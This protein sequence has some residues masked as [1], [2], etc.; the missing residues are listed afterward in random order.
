MEYIIIGSFSFVLFVLYDWNQI[1]SKSTLFK[2][3]FMLG[4]LL[5]IFTTGLLW[6]NDGSGRFY[7][8]P[9]LSLLFGLLSIISGAVLVYILFFAIPFEKAYVDGSRQE[10]VTEGVY[11]I[12]RHPGVWFL[13]FLYLFA[14]IA[15]GRPQIILGSFVFS[16]FN[17]LYVF[18]Q[19]RIFF[20]RIFAGYSEYKEK[21]SFIVPTKTGICNCFRYYSK[22]N[23]K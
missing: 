1:S 10:L 7:V 11:A 13:F 14:G 12:C 19:D 8:S 21:T 22:L 15:G 5:L 3:F 6:M 18:L 2:S 16:F 17:L 4:C 20:P 23:Q 9:A